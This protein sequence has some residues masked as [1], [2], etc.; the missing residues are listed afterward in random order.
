MSAVTGLD[1]PR[2]NQRNVVLVTRHTRLEELVVRHHT[3]EQARF[4]IEH[5]GADFSDYLR[6]N[7]AYAKALQVTVETLQAWGR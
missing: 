4:Y 5:L 6:E 7:A 1:R 2:G 3:L